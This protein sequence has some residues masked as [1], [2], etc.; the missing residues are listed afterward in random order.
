MMEK[1]S[2]AYAVGEEQRLYFLRK[3]QWANP[4]KN[5]IID[6][7]YKRKSNRQ[8]EDTVWHLNLRAG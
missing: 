1:N 2:E 6:T 4:G 5:G 7:L 3:K 8:K